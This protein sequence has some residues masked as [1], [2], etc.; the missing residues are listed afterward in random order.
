MTIFAYKLIGPRPGVARTA[1]EQ[2]SAAACKRVGP[3]VSS[4]A[5]PAMDEGGPVLPGRGH[6]VG[7]LRR[8]HSFHGRSHLSSS[9][10]LVP[11]RSSVRMMSVLSAVGPDRGPWLG[12]P[13]DSSS[14]SDTGVAHDGGGW[15][16][17][18][19]QLTS[20]SRGRVPSRGR[21]PS[22]ALTPSQFGSR[23]ISVVN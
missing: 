13:L 12:Q 2:E 5:R 15:Y 11:W 18:R 21:S 6:L 4:S 8:P 20:Q 16:P 1:T 17:P 9:R 23:V 3:P 19:P 14:T 7:H 22:T 10:P